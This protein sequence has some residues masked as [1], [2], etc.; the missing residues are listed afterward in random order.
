MATMS[1]SG[2][3]LSDDGFPQTPQSAMAASPVG[4]NSYNTY[5]ANMGSLLA[6]VTKAS[7]AGGAAQQANIEG[8]QR[9]QS[10]LA[11]PN[12]GTMPGGAVQ[13]N[14][15][16]N[17]ILNLE[18]GSARA[19]TENTLSG[20]MQPAVLSNEGQAQQAQQNSANLTSEINAQISAYNAMKPS[21]QLSSV[22]DANGNWY[23]YNTNVPPGQPPQQYEAGQIPPGVGG[24]PGGSPA[25]ADS[26]QTL[27]S[28]NNPY[29]IKMTSTT[30]DLFSGLGATPGPAAVDG[31]D[32][33]SFPDESTGEKA[34]RTL[35]T[36][37]TYANDSVDQALR[38]WSNYTGTG[39]YPGYNGDILKGTGIDPNATIK[40]LTSAQVD[41]VLA[42]MKKAESVQSSSSPSAADTGTL[43]QIAAEVAKGPSN[44]GLTY[45][46]GVSQIQSAYGSAGGYM[47]PRLLAAVQQINPSF[48]P[49][50][51][52]AQ[53]T[54]LASNT[55]T[56][57]TLGAQQA[58]L[59]SAIDTL[60]QDNSKL[61]PL[62]RSPIPILNDL[63]SGVASAFGS[64]ATNS[65]VQNYGDV[66]TQLLN[67][68]GSTGLGVTE[69]QSAVNSLLPDGLRGSQLITALNKA[70]ALVA[71][72][73]AA[74]SNLGNATPGATASTGTST[75][76]PATGT[77]PSGISYVISQ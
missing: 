35:L 55:G 61:N 68:L 44:G 66:R 4:S 67:I 23:Y 6:Y 20:I 38:Q 7:A 12:G 30:T 5:V 39:Q 47:V 2:Q 28:A 25:S 45:D 76:T 15:P 9:G 33:W 75:T 27:A 42:A 70:K 49:N 40:S 1:S 21:W 16:L 31:G 8:L 72:R 57:G 43:G 54:A 46:Q 29:G 50:Q 59:N 17:G 18:P 14:N 58:S 77:T 22:P 56:A 64:S 34:A 11:T 10:A 32:F 24:S 65:L 60:V 62:E 69:A 36:S 74:Y 37:S 63:T 3:I 41:V 48:N 13:S 19:G 53:G 71:Q 26:I 52:N 73:V 51:S